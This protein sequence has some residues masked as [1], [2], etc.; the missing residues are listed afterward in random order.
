MSD[1]RSAYRYALS[2]IGVANEAKLIDE[3]NRDFQLIEKII[4]D[5]R[6][7][8]LLLKNPILNDARKKSILTE[9]LE[10]KVSNLTFKFV[11]LLVSKDRENLLPEIIQ[12]FYRL[13][14]EQIGVLNVTAK[15]AVKFTSTQEQELIKRLAAATKKQVRVKYIVDQSLKGGFT[16]QFDDTVWDASV[17]HQLD[18]IRQKFIEG[19]A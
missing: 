14:D 6:E 8:S 19:V 1:N 18:L 9:I 4:I 15:T 13:R 2:I 11:M 3:V 16:I 5:V 12:Q 17:V 7:F 10:K